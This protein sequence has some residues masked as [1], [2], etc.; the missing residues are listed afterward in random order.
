VRLRRHAGVEAEH[1]RASRDLADGREVPRGIDAP[2]LR[3]QRRSQMAD[4][5][6]GERVAVGRRLGD[7]FE[8]DRARRTGAIVRNDRLAES[9]GQLACN[10]G[11]TKSVPPPG[12]TPTRKRIGLTG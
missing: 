4:V 3:E 12:A 6:D 2:R 9:L 10:G 1:Q 5:E 11:A 8:R 7:H